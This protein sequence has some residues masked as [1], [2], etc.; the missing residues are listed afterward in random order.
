M[1]HIA[2]PGLGRQLSGEAVKT[3]GEKCQKNPDVQIIVS[4]G[5]SSKAIEANVANALPAI[6]EAIIFLPLPYCFSSTPL[7]LAS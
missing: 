7:A 2:R 3:I 1:C 6:A 4:D 5:L